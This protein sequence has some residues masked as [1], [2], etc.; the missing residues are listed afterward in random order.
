MWL[1]V[2]MWLTSFGRLGWNTSVHM[3]VEPKGA[4]IASQWR[5]CDLNA[6][7]SLMKSFYPW[8]AYI[9]EKWMIQYGVK[10]VGTLPIVVVL[11]RDADKIFFESGVD[12]LQD[13][14]HFSKWKF[15]PFINLKSHHQTPPTHHP[16]AY[17][18]TKIP[19]PIRFISYHRS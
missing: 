15:H 19:H 14:H 9:Q 4:T 1:H 13:L 3:C 6:T 18:N 17:I 11:Y 16:H 2:L 7:E 12:L 5:N 10:S 8:S